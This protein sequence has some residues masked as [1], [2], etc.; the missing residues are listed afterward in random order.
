MNC[1]NADSKPTLIAS[2][3]GH[4]RPV[5]CLAQTRSSTRDPAAYPR[6]VTA[7]D[8]GQRHCRTDNKAVCARSN[9]PVEFPVWQVL[10]SGVLCSPTGRP[11]GLPVSSRRISRLSNIRSM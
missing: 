4:K 8:E 7:H 5:V 2:R 11:F 9:F 10:Y 3:A 1:Q 6:D